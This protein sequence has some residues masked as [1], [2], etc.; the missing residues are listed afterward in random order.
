M[1][2]WPKNKQKQACVNVERCSTDIVC[3]RHHVMVGSQ[4]IVN[5]IFSCMLF[6]NDVTKITTGGMMIIHISIITPLI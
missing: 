6:C 3:V 4:I 2:V 5:F 1:C